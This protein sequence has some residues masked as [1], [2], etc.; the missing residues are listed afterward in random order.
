MPVQYVIRPL[1]NEYQDYRGYAGKIAS[2]SIE[3]GEEIAVM[4]SGATTT[5]TA[6]ESPQGEVASAGEAE[7]VTIRIAD[8]LDISRGRC[9]RVRLK[10]HKPTIS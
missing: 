8:N 2:G 6:I 4:P 1:S 9:S 5:I 3:V 7:S 10:S